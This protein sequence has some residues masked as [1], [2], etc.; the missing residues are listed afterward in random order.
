ML[1]TTITMLA[2]MLLVSIY[3]RAQ[4]PPVAVPGTADAK[5]APPSI[6]VGIIMPSQSNKPPKEKEGYAA[7]C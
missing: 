3:P 4:E 1:K 7:Y 5:G 6:M 2:V